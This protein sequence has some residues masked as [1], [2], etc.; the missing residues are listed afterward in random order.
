MK[1]TLAALAAVAGLSTG[2][3]A[4]GD[5]D[6]QALPIRGEDRTKAAEAGLRLARE[7][8]TWREACV[9]ES[10]AR[11]RAAAAWR[12]LAEKQQNRIVQLEKRGVIG[13]M[14]VDEADA[15][16][17]GK[18]AS[19]RSAKQRTVCA[20]AE[21]EVAR[22]RVR[23]AEARLDIARVESWDNRDA[24]AEADRKAAQARLRKARL[25]AARSERDVARASL[26][27]AGAD[28]DERKAL[29]A[30]W[31]K[32][33]ERYEALWRALHTHERKAHDAKLSLAEA[34]AAELD[35]EDRVEKRRA[36]ILAAEASIKAA[37]AEVKEDAIDPGPQPASA[38][39][40]RR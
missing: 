31:T 21:L 33:Q 32:R 14:E 34:R 35:A 8:L 30:G 5:R 4:G 10:E 9:K 23:E 25:D 13:R 16:L 1:R 27:E 37:E 18:Q 19:E 11:A 3:A 17:R 26:N 22:A 39:S 38:T 29:V 6:G 12:E 7:R 40:P 28:L 36:D 15:E 24:R 20:H 2:M